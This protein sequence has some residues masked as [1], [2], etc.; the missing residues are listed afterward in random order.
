MLNS[1][2][3]VFVGRLIPYF[4]C[5]EEKLL[6]VNYNFGVWIQKVRKREE[7]EQE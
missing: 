7:I 4:D 1:V 3:S 6:I 5:L 2:I